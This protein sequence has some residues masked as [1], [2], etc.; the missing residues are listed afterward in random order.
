MSYGIEPFL[1]PPSPAQI[2]PEPANNEGMAEVQNALQQ[3]LLDDDWATFDALVFSDESFNIE[4]GQNAHGQNFLH[5]AIQMGSRSIALNLAKRAGEQGLDIINTEDLF[6]F[7]PLA[8]AVESQTDD[9]ELVDELLLAGANVKLSEALQAAAQGGHAEMATALMAAGVNGPEVLVDILRHNS[10]PDKVKAAKLLISLGMDATVALES[11]VKKEQWD[12]ISPL[13]LLGAKGSEALASLSNSDDRKAMARLISA[14]A[15]VVMALKILA[16]KANSPENSGAMRSLIGS[17]L[18]SDDDSVD[19]HTF[20][21]RHRQDINWTSKLALLQ[22]AKSGNIRAVQT[23]STVMLPID[24]L[25][26]RELAMGGHVETIKTL[27]AAGLVNSEEFL[28]SFALA[29]NLAAARAL[30]NAGTPTSETLTRLCKT[31]GGRPQYQPNLDA[32]KLLIFAGAAPS[33]PLSEGVSDDINR[34]KAEISTLDSG[35]MVERFVNAAKCGDVVDMAMLL[36]CG[37]DTVAALRLLGESPPW[38]GVPKAKDACLNAGMTLSEILVGQ[39]KAGNMKAAKNLIGLTDTTA[40]TLTELIINGDTDTART[41]V[42]AL[43]SGQRALLQ[44]AQSN[45]G[46]LMRALIEIG[47]DAPAAV[48]SLLEANARE[49][50]G[51]LMA[52]GTDV[53]AILTRAISAEHEPGQNVVQG[54]TMLGAN[55]H[56]ALLRALEDNDF[57]IAQRVLNLKGNA[58]AEK[59]LFA[60]IAGDVPIDEPGR[61]RLDWLVRAQIDTDELIRKLAEDGQ[62]A[63]LETLIDLNVPTA[64]VLIDLAIEGNRLDAQTLIAAGGDVA[65]AMDTLRAYDEQDAL[66]VLVLAAAAA[67]D[68][69]SQ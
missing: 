13:I 26:C 42:P 31:P 38:L 18:G 58:V 49:A 14:G 17:E 36:G 66:N 11:A 2:E 51:R 45:D 52:W 46:D 22:L 15:D 60:L 10:D 64:K 63:W 9:R 7:T 59:A 55:Y 47:A 28:K 37:V 16:T 65:V 48:L 6:G 27:I 56:I 54:L 21:S 12:A 44:A 32:I 20:S 24:E 69:A 4:T 30:I 23:L 35:A 33:H 19:E 41:F 39:V 29:G 1:G 62:R 53:H 25:T 3:A 43:I 34:K 57:A 67:S 68:T 8:Y 61:H 50:A 40:D 5:V